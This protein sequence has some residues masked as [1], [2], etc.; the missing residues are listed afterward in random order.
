[1]DFKHYEIFIVFAFFRFNSMCLGLVRCLSLSMNSIFIIESIMMYSLSL[2]FFF[3]PIIVLVWR[4]SKEMWRDFSFSCSPKVY[5]TLW[6]FCLAHSAGSFMQTLNICVYSTSFICQHWLLL[7]FSLLTP[8]D[9]K[10]TCTSLLIIEMEISTIL[11]Y[12]W[13]IIAMTCCNVE[14]SICLHYTYY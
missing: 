8:T 3:S 11:L 1:M 12:V 13:Q 2:F 5:L 10:V 9:T 14:S 6:I 4:K 7:M